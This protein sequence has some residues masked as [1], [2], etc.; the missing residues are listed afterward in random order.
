M[1][2]DGSTSGES[3]SVRRRVRVVGRVQGVGFR[4]WT[5]R[6]ASGLGLCGRVRNLPDGS[7]EIEVEGDRGSVERMIELLRRGPAS[8]SV[9]DVLEATPGSDPLPDGFEVAFR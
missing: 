8:A 6:R 2:G 3:A 5:A 7:V 1:S 9:R 4:A